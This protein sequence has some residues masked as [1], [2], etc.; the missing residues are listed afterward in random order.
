[1]FPDPEGE[2]P[3]IGDVSFA[4]FDFV[5]PFAVSEEESFFIFIHVRVRGTGPRRSH[6][7]S[8]PSLLTRLPP[9][10]IMHMPFHKAETHPGNPRAVEPC[11]NSIPST[12][13]QKPPASSVPK[14]QKKRHPLTKTPRLSMASCLFAKHPNPSLEAH[15]LSISLSLT[16]FGGKE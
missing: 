8:R 6:S 10:I 2:E 11:L 16:Y 12:P 5:P 13:A 3:D 1:M 14:C 15:F 7:T 4:A 9:S